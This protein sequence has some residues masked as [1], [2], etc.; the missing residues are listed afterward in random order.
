MRVLVDTSVWIDHLR[1]P[2]SA[3]VGLLKS[4]RVLMHTAVLGELACGTLPNRAVLLADLDLIPKATEATPDEAMAFIERNALSGKGLGW[5]DIQLLASARLS[6]STLLTK[7]K[8]LS[9]F[10]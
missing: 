3:L 10:T 7:D 8:R 5:V 1:K 4:N 9:K 6:S 2:N